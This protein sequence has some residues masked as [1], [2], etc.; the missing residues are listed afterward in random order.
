VA[1][2]FGPWVSVRGVE[3]I[4]AAPRPT[5]FALNH[6][7]AVETI[8]IAAVL[9]FVRG[10][11]PGF[12]VDWMYVHLP[13][14][15]WI[16]RLCEPIPVFSK[17]AKFRLYERLRL[18]ARR[19]SPVDGAAA[20]LVAV[21]DVALFP[22]GRRNGSAGSLEAGRP[23]IGRLVLETGATVVPIGLRFPAA[24]RSGRVPLVGRLEVEVGEELRFDIERLSLVA[25]SSGPVNAGERRAFAALVVERVM[26]ELSRLSGKRR[27]RHPGEAHQI[28]PSNVSGLPAS[29]G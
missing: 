6:N 26:T 11:V 4:A 5:V 1:L 29:A 9:T 20:A 7:N 17:P 2:V 27:R 16:V 22:E 21:R 25:E 23:G 14:V 8:L 10:R 13:V 12:L 19:R 28:R 24:T 15:G 18:S 3:R